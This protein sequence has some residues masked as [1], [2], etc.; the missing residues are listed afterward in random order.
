MSN[1][2]SKPK[3]IDTIIDNW[4]GSVC[5]FFILNGNVT[6]YAITD[7]LLYDFLKIE[8][9]TAGFSNVIELA[10]SKAVSY[11]SDQ[12]E[13][14]ITS[15]A[16]SLMSGSK[17]HPM[18]VIVRNPEMMFPNIPDGHANREMVVDFSIL[19]DALISKEFI[20]SR[21]ILIFVSEA[22]QTF[23]QRFLGA[24]TRGMLLDVDFPNEEVRHEFILDQM[25]KFPLLNNGEIG[26]KELARI[27]AG[28]TLMS[29]ED[30][31][32]K[33]K[34]EG[35]MKREQVIERK[36]E[37]I[38]KEYGDVLEIMDSEGYGFGDFAGQ[39]HLKDY[40]R[41]VVI[42]P[43]LNGD[44]EIVPKG[45][46][47][48]G[49]PGTGKT[50][51]ARCLAGEARMSFVE[52]KPQKLQDMWVGNSEKN[53]AKALNCIRSITPVGVFID[54]IDQVFGRSNGSESNGVKGNFFSMFLTILSEPAN[55]GK[56]IWIGATN[57]P[58]KLDE[59][60][61]R[62]GRL[63]KKMPFLPPEEGD[64]KKVLE[65]YL[66]K[67][68]L[69]HNISDS[70]LIRIAKRTDGYTQA[71]IEGIVVKTTEVA[72]RKKRTT[73]TIEDLDYAMEC[74]VKSESDSLEE[75]TQIAIKECN[76]WEFLPDKYKTPN[77]KLR[78]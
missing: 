41:E 39:D 23:N 38:R 2:M 75:M 50:H 60:L 19:Y 25:D 58:N 46:L 14:S 69:G 11:N 78:K 52:L 15:A 6:D 18:A 1:H 68:R 36:T 9:K 65:I 77:S 35:K 44:F 59:A 47:Y 62:T 64:R 45:L 54:E 49:P 48:T 8:L 4:K 3:W 32:L 12:R 17:E 16:A 72:A 22:K 42:N 57:Y 26:S 43:M 28:L 55:R 13:Y 34:M 29:I 74:I 76:D 27:T 66:N 67:S 20:G 33:A 56:I 63:D 53:F 70:E 30:V 5:N 31:V 40:H 51:F 7:I 21:N 73:I 61:K 24:Q 71:E 37:L 10:F